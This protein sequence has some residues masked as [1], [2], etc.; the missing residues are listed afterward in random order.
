MNPTPRLRPYRTT[1]RTLLTVAAAGV[2][3]A[4]VTSGGNDKPTS[5]QGAKSAENPLG[6][7]ADAALEVVIFKGGYGDD[8]AKN[9]EALYQQRFPNAKVDHKGI[10]K[11]GEALQPRFVANTPPDVVDNTGA[12]RLDIATLVSAKQVSDLSQLLDAPSF[13]VPGKTV[14]DT[15]LPGVVDDGTFDK[16]PLTLNFTY[17]V[18]GLWYSKKLFAAKGWTFPT[19]WDE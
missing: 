11:I 4:C 18:W 16:V 6:V 19:T 5:N 17:T 1:R 7:P 10:Q 2:T 3:S 9:A 12:S 13:D 15:L 14:R 8:Y